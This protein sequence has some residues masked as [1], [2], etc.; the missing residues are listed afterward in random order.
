MFK[1]GV[2]IWQLRQSLALLEWSGDTPLA[3]NG[4]FTRWC[5]YYCIDGLVD[6]RTDGRTDW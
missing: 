2:S 5:Q 6:G 4:Q 1:L 3:G